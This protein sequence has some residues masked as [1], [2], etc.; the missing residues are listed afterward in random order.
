MTTNTVMARR[1][2][3]SKHYVEKMSRRTLAFKLLLQ[4]S[5]VLNKYMATNKQ[6]ALE[7]DKP[8]LAN[9]H[10]P[11]IKI[12]TNFPPTH[13]EGLRFSWQ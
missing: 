3:D 7:F 2:G 5:P 6:Y 11:S 10:K 1:N 9:G 8:G 4:S 12:K 13:V